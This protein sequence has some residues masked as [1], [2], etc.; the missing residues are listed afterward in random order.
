MAQVQEKIQTLEDNIKEATDGK[1]M[2]KVEKLTQQKEKAVEWKEMLE[3]ITP[4]PPL[5]LRHEAEIEK[6]NKEM[7]PL[8][9]LEL[10]TKG[11]LLSLRKTT[12][13]SREGRRN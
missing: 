13:L 11:R 10:E 4:Q 2:K 6:L 5:K 8:L 1:K 7:P 3:G 9:K 12:T